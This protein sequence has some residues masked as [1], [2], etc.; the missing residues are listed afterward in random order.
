MALINCSMEKRTVIVTSGQ[1]NVTSV[2]LE[3]I[4]DS[5][6]VVAARDFVAGANPD[7]TGNI[8]NSITLSNSASSGGPQNDGS[9]TTVNKVIVT[10]DF[11][12]N[13]APTTD[14][15][16]DI[17]PAGEATAVHLVPVKLQGTFAIPA[18]P[19]KVTFT[20]SNV[21]DFAS[22]SS[23]TDFYAYDNPGDLVTIMV[24][25]IAA[26]TN[27]FIDEDATIVITNSSDSTADQ[28]YQIDRVNTFDSCLVLPILLILTMVYMYLITLKQL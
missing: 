23:T 1:S 2:T 27:D 11:K 17:D 20:A 4:P 3:I 7:T 18:S 22:S 15:V 16:L 8:I 10:V 12:N 21:L 14:V 19:S 5:G 6:Y 25:T 28:D 26:T 13:Y 24:M 9:Y